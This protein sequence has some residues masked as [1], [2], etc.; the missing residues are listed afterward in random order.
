MRASSHQEGPKSQ[1]SQIVPIVTPE[2]FLYS[3]MSR[4]IFIITCAAA[5]ASVSHANKNF[6]PDWTFTGSSLADAE[7]LGAARWTARNGEVIGTPSSPDGGWLLFNNPVQDVQMA[8]SFQCAAGCQAGLVLRLEKTADGFKGVFVSISETPG[9]FAVTLDAQGRFLTKEPL[10][11]GGGT[12]PAL[13]PPQPQGALDAA[14]AGGPGRG[15]PGRGVPGRGGAGRGGPPERSPYTRPEYVFRPG[16]WNTLESILDANILRSWLNDGPEAGVASGR[17]DDQIA[18]YGR[19][20]LYVGG[21]T[22][23]RYRAIETKDLGRRV[24]SDE[25]VGGGFRLQRLNDF[26]H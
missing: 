16:E 2:G 18:R 10:E 11:R 6:S 9:A 25:Q 14:R 12:G 13:P 7:Q 19:V 23:V 21:T 4:F 5:M 26:Y 1:S 3:A 20:G 22:E 15:G 17:V 24:F 8:T